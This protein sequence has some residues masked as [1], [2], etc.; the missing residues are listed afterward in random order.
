MKRMMM[1]ALLIAACTVLH[2]QNKRP[3]TSEEQRTEFKA[4]M[5]AYRT[6]LQLS[7]DQSAKV[8]TINTSFYESLAKIKSDGGSKLSRYKKFK[9][10]SREKDK[11]MKEVLNPDQYK[12]YKEQ[13]EEFKEEIKSRRSK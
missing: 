6:K 4:K 2:A 11:K 13:Q 8:E 1:V 10:A 5:D 9:Q 12:I 3:N 7:E